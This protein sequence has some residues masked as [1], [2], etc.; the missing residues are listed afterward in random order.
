VGTGLLRGRGCQCDNNKGEIWLEKAAQA[1]QPD[2]QVSLAEYLLR[3]KPSADSL[4]GAMVWL[5]RAVKQGNSPAK[6]RLSAILAANPSADIR[7]PSRALALSDNLQHD[8]KKDPSLLEIRA[9]AYASR[10]DYGAAIKAESQALVEATRLG[11]NVQPLQQRA[12]AYASHQPW[13]GDLLD[14]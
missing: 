8:Y 2:A 14:F 5:D 12:S 9:A 11:W 10:G 6:L 7:D 4:A 3:D 13:Y 1:D